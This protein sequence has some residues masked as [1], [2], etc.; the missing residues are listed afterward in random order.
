MAGLLTGLTLHFF[1]VQSLYRSVG[2]P[3]ARIVVI[4]LPGVVVRGPRSYAHLALARTG[5]AV[6]SGRW[7]EWA[8]ELI[9]Q[10]SRDGAIIDL[11][12]LGLMIFFGTK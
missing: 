11:A 9:G 7:N 4:L 8:F 6:Y 12:V 1:T 10:V 5:V 3:I 2:T